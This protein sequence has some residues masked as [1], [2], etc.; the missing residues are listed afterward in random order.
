MLLTFVRGNP[1]AHEAPFQ[2]PVAQGVMGLSRLVVVPSPRVPAPF[3]PQQTGMLL[4]STPHVLFPPAASAITPFNGLPPAHPSPVPGA[5][6][7]ATGV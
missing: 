5:L 3:A 2:V 1:P 7:T 4:T 6:Q